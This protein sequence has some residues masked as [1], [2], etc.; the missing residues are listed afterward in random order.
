MVVDRLL[1]TLGV[2]I[3]VAA[4]QAS[5]LRKRQYVLLLDTTTGAGLPLVIVLSSEQ[6]ISGALSMSAMFRIV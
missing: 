5:G 4:H 6:V 2:S 1:A 3:K